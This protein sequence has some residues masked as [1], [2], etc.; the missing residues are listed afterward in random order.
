[1]AFL[2]IFIIIL[3]AYLIKNLF[4]GFLAGFFY[5]YSLSNMLAKKFEPR[6]NNTLAFTASLSLIS[7]VGA[8][9]YFFYQLNEM[10]IFVVITFIPLFIVILPKIKSKK[11]DLFN[12]E[13][14][15]EYF[16]FSEKI[17][18]NIKKLLVI[19]YAALYFVLIK[20]LFIFQ[21]S[22]A[23]RS[24]WK[25][26]PSEFL[27]FYFFAT[28]ILII[29][30]FSSN[31]KRYFP[32]I[33]A[34]FLLSSGIALITYKIG[35]GFDQFIHQATEKVITEN[36]LITPKP[37]YYLGQYS[38]VV[39]LSK[40]LLIN[41]AIIDKLLVIVLFSTLLPL[42]IYNSF[43]ES[44]YKEHL[45]FFSLA[46]LMFPFTSFITTTPQALANLFILLI[47]FSSLP[48]LLGKNFL[49][50][51]IFLVLA[52]LVIHPLAG[53]PVIIFLGFVLVYKIKSEISKKILFP[54][55]F[56]LSSFLIPLIFIINSKIN[57]LRV[58]LNF[59]QK[60]EILKSIYDSQVYFVNNFNLIFDF[61]YFYKSNFYSIIF[62]LALVIMLLIYKNNKFLFPYFLSFLI[63]FIN[64]LILKFV[65]T[66][67]FLIDY[68][69]GDY[70]NRILEIS[71]YFLYPII[72]YGTIV[73]LKKLSKQKEIIRLIFIIFISGLIT[74]SLYLSYPR[75][76]DY[77]TIN[78]FNMSQ[79]DIETVRWINQDAGDK[80]FIV[81]ANQQVSAAAIKEYGF[82]KYFGNQFYYPIPTSSPLYS[83]YLKMV[84]SEPK[85][86]YIE[87][88]MTTLGVNQG[89]FVM[90]NYW[91]KF[92]EISN[93]A[94][95]SADYYKLIDNGTN[96]IF[97][98]T[99]K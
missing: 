92:R 26:I 1:M 42:T 68:E 20:Y 90:N 24:P 93:K 85:R 74:S 22:D 43:K 70:A 50:P 86:E 75:S 30:I 57:N 91:W 65:I 89:Y 49:L 36:G 3:N 37:L 84:D 45:V 52:T 40:V 6:L 21:T 77:E 87:E 15:K 64:F 25:I 83:Y 31:K 54:L 78:F 99:I 59:P 19:I 38:L 61:I 35:F 82:K 58:N 81:L 62:F 80:N 69:Q 10:A 53:I 88:A 41:Y 94:R 55:F 56:I 98:Y 4:L 28:Y 13:N 11:K 18:T 39:I 9:V 14:I 51:I 34:H 63:L 27:L 12:I 66:I 29:I 32:L 95:S 60:D 72:F 48:F 46:F 44:S 79:A 96:M 47:I 71:F 5:L 76:D 73:F 33:F 67:N 97:K 23:I 2:S 7:F 16:Y 8:I 17:S